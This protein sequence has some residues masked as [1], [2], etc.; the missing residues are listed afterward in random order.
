MGAPLLLRRPLPPCRS[1]S[2]LPLPP[3]VDGPP[4]AEDRNGLVAAMLSISDNRRLLGRGEP[5]NGTASSRPCF[6][7]DVL[8]GLCQE[9]APGLAGCKGEK[10]ESDGGTTPW[11]LVSPVMVWVMPSGVGAVDVV[12]KGPRRAG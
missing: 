5:S 12:N 2:W 10:P 9:E 8:D 1:A 6:L 4:W 11:P 7:L 3:K